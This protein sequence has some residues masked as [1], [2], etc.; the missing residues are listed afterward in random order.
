LLWLAA[1][2]DELSPAA[3]EA[4]AE[5]AGSLY[6]SA[7][8][9]YEIGTM[10]RGGRL[11]LP[12]PPARWFAEAIA[13][14]GLREIPVTGALAATAAELPPHHLDLCDRVLVAT[15]IA[16]GLTVLSP[17]PHL[18]AYEGVRTLW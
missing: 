12:R 13:F 10:Q 16:H 9:A 2:P 11:E 7:V 17:D 1:A 4:L 14:H 8:T 3:R 6:V 18:R 5:N 15:A